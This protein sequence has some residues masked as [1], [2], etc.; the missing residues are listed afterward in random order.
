MV[1]VT[2]CTA[3]EFCYVLFCELSTGF[4][5]ETVLLLIELIFLVLLDWI[6]LSFF[7]DSF[8]DMFFYSG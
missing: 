6:K 3:G 7:V 5:S 2:G 1:G 4:W 8:V